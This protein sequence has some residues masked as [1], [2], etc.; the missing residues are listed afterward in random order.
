[1]RARIAEIFR[2]MLQWRCSELCEGPTRAALSTETNPKCGFARERRMSPGARTRR[3]V[4][5][6]VGATSSTGDIS[7]NHSQPKRTDISIGVTAGLLLRL[8]LD[9]GMESNSGPKKD[10]L[11]II[12]D[13]SPGDSA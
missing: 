3:D 7:S 13:L 2:A 1:M 6:H 4:S 10:S 12:D 5:S 9:V 8:D 11:H